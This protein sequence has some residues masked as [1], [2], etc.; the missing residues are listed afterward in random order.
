MASYPG[1]LDGG[2]RAMVLEPRS[3]PAPATTDTPQGLLISVKT[4]FETSAAFKTFNVNASSPTAKLLVMNLPTLLFSGT[5]DLDPLLCPFGSISTTEFKMDPA[6]GGKSSSVIVEFDSVAGA[7]EAREHLHGQVYAG[8][9]LK[10]EYLRSGNISPPL[11]QESSPTWLPTR[12]NT[13][14]ASAGNKN[15]NPLA[16]PFIHEQQDRLSASSSYSAVSRPSQ[17]RVPGVSAVAPVQYLDMDT[18]SPHQHYYQYTSHVV[19]PQTLL[20]YG[21][22][23]NHALHG[24]VD[25]NQRV[26]SASPKCVCLA[27]P[28]MQRASQVFSLLTVDGMPTLSLNPHGSMPPPLGNR[29]STRLTRTSTLDHVFPPRIPIYC[30]C[31]LR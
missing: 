26:L 20:C 3:D 4:S 18:Y 13:P 10:L 17:G 23:Y 22:S 19:P 27:L 29:S 30:F 2:D 6:S 8:F 21:P 9:A 15:L 16:T 1:F 12:D 14:L 7:Q 31:A 28:H 24:R 25:P 11:D 5:S